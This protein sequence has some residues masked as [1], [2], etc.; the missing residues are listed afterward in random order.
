MMEIQRVRII[1]KASNFTTRFKVSKNKDSRIVTPQNDIT[2][3]LVV[4]SGRFL[5]ATGGF[6]G[7]RIHFRDLFVF[8]SKVM[9]MS[10]LVSPKF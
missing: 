3:E 10:Y 7:W 9:A 4:G 6:R 8:Q 2:L 5:D 1:T